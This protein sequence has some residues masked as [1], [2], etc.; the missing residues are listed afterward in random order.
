MSYLHAQIER[1]TYANEETGYAVAKVQAKGHEGLVAVVGILPSP[2]PGEILKM[3]GAWESH[4]KYGQQF[5]VQSC[6]TILPA[7]AHA[8]QKYLGSGLIKGIGPVMAGRIVKLFGEQA[9]DVIEHQAERLAEVQGIGKK[10][11]D[12]IRQAWE[13][14]KAIRCVMIFLQ[15]HSV[16]ATYAA[17]I[18]K[19]YGN[20]AIA[21]VQNNPYRLAQDIWGIGFKTADK[22]AQALGIAPDSPLRI[23]AG[24]V[25]VLH[26]LADEGHVF[27]P[28]EPLY[29]KSGE[30]L[31]VDRS[32]LEPGIARLAL[33][34]RIV[35]DPSPS[36]SQ[37]EN[38]GR[39]VY[40]AKYHH[41]EVGTAK[42]LSVL[43]NAP[44]NVRRVDVDK[45]LEWV[46]GQMSMTLADK[47]QEAVRCVLSGKVVV[48]TGGPGTG[49]TTI[50]RSILKIYSRLTQRILL[51]APTGR[52]AKRMSEATGQEAKTIHRLLE[53]SPGSGSFKHN[54]EK[55]LAADLLVVDEA[56]MIDQVLMY[57]LV[58]AVP[59]GC[60]VVLVGD[61][62]QL[63]S[64]GAGNVLRDVIASGVVPV[65]T[66]NEIFRQ[67]QDSSIIINAHRINAGHL[68]GLQPRQDPDDFYFIHQEEPEKA[69]EVIINLV[70][71]RIP[72]RFGLD[73]INDIQVLSPMH[74]GVIGAGNL[75]QV[76]QEALNP[77]GPCVERGARKFRVGDKVMQIRNNYDKEIFNGDIGRVVRLDQEM[78]ELMVR[79][80]GRDVLYEFM[81]LDELVLAYAAT[82]HKSQGS[83]YPAVVM[84][85]LTTHYIMLQRNLIYTG[86]T[87]GRRLVVLVGTKKALAMAIRNNKTGKR[88][89]NLDGRL[90]GMGLV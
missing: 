26:E 70:K 86:I 76:L 67:A 43:I 65:V 5:K 35:L 4:P 50:I 6:E 79:F 54:P 61:I 32:L 2:N 59:P 31:E 55:P 27:F 22:I 71:N 12:M 47:Q 40:L 1:I 74:R 23:D 51:A 16:S 7:T 60:A 64:V 34:N 90:R 58:Q 83:E 53:F 62:D 63:P 81:E 78:R 24:I 36:T 44:R 20:E 28:E 69:L 49:K 87:R 72:G 77:S 57:H 45:A 29:A 25:H 38:L 75:N 39:P 14:Q 68:P 88:Y 33:E 52:A 85:V 8:I 11:I 13:D 89:S 9:L 15:G 10:R 17:K 21:I 82:V 30:I 80:D 73:P 84:P 37:E 66:L 3:Q 18:Y 46:Q 41:C 48:I 56:S 19:Q 42:R